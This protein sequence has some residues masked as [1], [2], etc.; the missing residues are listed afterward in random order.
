MP[1]YKLKDRWDKLDIIGKLISGVVLAVI[2]VIIKSGT[3]RIA[4]SQHRGDLVRAL[5]ADLTTKDQRTRQ[6]IALIALDHSVGGENPQLVIEIA[7]RLVL[8]TTGYSAA[9]RSQ[10]SILGSV[11]FGV[12]KKRN[13]ARADSLQRAVE[14][15]FAS[16]VSADSGV[17]AS[18]RSD[19][20]TARTLVLKDSSAQFATRLIARFSSSVVF[21]QFQGG[22][23]RK[24]MERLRKSLDSAGFV[25]PGVEYITKPFRSSVRYFHA[26]DSMLAARAA[27]ISANFLQQERLSVESLKLQNLSERG[28]RVPRGQIEVWLNVSTP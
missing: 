27:K 20:D 13:R 3:D 28:L 17:R 10:E 7:E 23:Q 18:L 25:A 14:Q 5:I 19:P 26:D 24:T 22:V 11:A 4:A 2:A 21:L 6:D 15:R 1:E 12:L 8:D 16:R 9:D